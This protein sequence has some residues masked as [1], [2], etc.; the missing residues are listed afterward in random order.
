M[1]KI[2]LKESI[3]NTEIEMFE[4][5]AMPRNVISELPKGEDFRFIFIMLYLIGI[6]I[7]GKNTPI[8]KESAHLELNWNITSITNEKANKARRA[9][10]CLFKRSFTNEGEMKMKLEKYL[11][12][13]NSLT[14]WNIY[15]V[16]RS[17]L[18]TSFGTLL[19]YGIL[20]GTLGK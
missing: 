16:D 20:I 3:K 12:V 19:T 1:E 7:C 5:K 8:N 10:K 14:L 2:K 4:N 15:T 17:L 9:M 6:E 13:E 18:I 11:D